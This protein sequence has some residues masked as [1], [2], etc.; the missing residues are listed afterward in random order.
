V[1]AV[2]S[3]CADAADEARMKVKAAIAANVFEELLDIAALL[4]M[5]LV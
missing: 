5:N 3:I 2:F 4:L 1:S